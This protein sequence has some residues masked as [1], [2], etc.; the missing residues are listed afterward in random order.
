MQRF[1]RVSLLAAIFAIAGVAT[2]SAQVARPQNLAGITGSG[3]LATQNLVTQ[4]RWGGRGGGHGGG[5]RHGHYRGGRGIG[6]G[7]AAGALIG[8]AYAASRYPAYSYPGYSYGAPEYYYED[9]S[10]DADGYCRQ[11]FQSY[12]PASGTYLG[13]DGLRHPCP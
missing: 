12:D 9:A 5:H 10:P 4:V 2:A 11:R 3:D 8:G 6:L 13:Y 7:I 1:T